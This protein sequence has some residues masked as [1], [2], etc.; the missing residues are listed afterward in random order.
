MGRH[1]I[2]LDLDRPGKEFRIGQRGPCQP[3]ARTRRKPQTSSSTRT[4]RKP[5]L[6]R[7]ATVDRITRKDL[8]SGRSRVR[9]AVGAPSRTPASV[10]LPAKT[11]EARNEDDAGT[12]RGCQDPHRIPTTGTG[13]G[14]EAL[15]EGEGG[16]TVA[17]T[18][19]GQPSSYARSRRQARFRG[20]SSDGAGLRRMGSYVR[21]S[22]GFVV[23]RKARSMTLASAPSG[24][25]SGA[26]ESRR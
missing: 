20:P 21:V 8:L 13:E 26:A 12:P 22:L 24:R 14:R 15:G 18:L 19:R 17:L 16:L 5:V 6:T 9:V 1:T 25:I 2:P 10:L 11:Q 23:G 3:R 4:T 7:N